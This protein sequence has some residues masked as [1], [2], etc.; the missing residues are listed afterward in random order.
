MGATRATS[1]AFDRCYVVFV[2]VG[3]AAAARLVKMAMALWV[4]IK[5]SCDCLVHA[6]NRR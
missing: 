4:R 1:D 5:V 2:A 6:M 3:V